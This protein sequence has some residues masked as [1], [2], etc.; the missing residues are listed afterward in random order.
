[1]YLFGLE[2]T[3]DFPPDVRENEKIGDNTNLLMGKRQY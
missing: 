1:M 2:K 3:K